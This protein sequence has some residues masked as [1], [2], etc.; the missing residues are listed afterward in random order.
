M[1]TDCYDAQSDPIV[2]F[3]AFYGPKKELTEI[4][5]ILFSKE[6]YEHILSQYEC[7][8]ISKIAACNGDLPVWSLTHGGKEIAFYLSHTGSAL[9]GSFT[10]EVNHLTGASRFIMFGSCGSLDNTVTDGRFIIPTEAYRGEGLS[11]YFAPPQ[12]YI[13]VKNADR[14]AELFTELN[15]PFVSGRIWTTDCPL[16]ETVNLVSQRKKE[17]CI[18]VE[19]EVAGVQA[20][21]DYYGFE[22]YDFLSAGDVL[23]EDGYQ[24]ENLADANHNLDK[25][26]IAL[27]IAEKL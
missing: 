27:Q 14:L 19:M 21:C 16:R 22:L 12:D 13:T 9:A 18:A 1:I 15:I 26:Q 4:C 23:A 11:Y 24:V 20:V 3:E 5:M 6:I 2:N 17:G 7:R 8:Q 25:L 10:A